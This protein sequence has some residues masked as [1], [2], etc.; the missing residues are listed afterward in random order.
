MLR[1]LPQDAVRFQPLPRAAYCDDFKNPEF[2]QEETEEIERGRFPFRPYSQF[3]LLP[4][5]K[6][7]GLGC[8]EAALGKVRTGGDRQR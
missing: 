4:P 6:C 1:L 2:S 8:G 3:P 5:V 7:F